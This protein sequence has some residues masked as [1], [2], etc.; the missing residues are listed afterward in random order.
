LGADDE[1]ELRRAEYVRYHWPDVRFS[2]GV[3]PHQ[4][5]KY[6]ADPEGAARAVDEAISQ[7]PLTRGLGEIGLDYH[8]DFSPRETQQAVVRAQVG[9]ALRRRLPIVIHTRE[10]EA[11]TFSILEETGAGGVGA[12]FHCFTG[13]AAMARR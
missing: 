5:Q 4:A 8:Y 7:Q 3:H 9:L 11:D 12:V 10:A 13:D 1:D 2:I 6:A